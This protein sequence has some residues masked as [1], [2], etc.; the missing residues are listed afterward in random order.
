M[1]DNSVFITGIADGAIEQALGDLPQWA[2]QSTAEAIEGIL[3]K[4]LDLQTKALSQIV[5]KA[6]SG[7][8]SLDTKELNDEFGKMVKDLKENNFV[9]RNHSYK[10]T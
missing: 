10:N 4:T 9:T 3:Q 8:N 6:T 7:D 5:K 1:A 2:T